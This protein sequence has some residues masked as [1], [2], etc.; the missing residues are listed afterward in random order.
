[1]GDIDEDGYIKIM[2]ITHEHESGN[3]P[4][5]V[6]DYYQFDSDILLKLMKIGLQWPS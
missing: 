3:D 2:P 6:V 4:C 5:L 1:M